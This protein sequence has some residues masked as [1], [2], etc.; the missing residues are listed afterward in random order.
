[1][2]SKKIVGMLLAAAFVMAGGISVMAQGQ[3]VQGVVKLRKADGTESPVAGATVEAYRTDTRSGKLPE[4]TTNEKGEFGWAAMPPSQVF[5]VAVSGSGIGPKIQPGVRGGTTTLVIIVEE[6]AG[7]RLSEE[8]VRQVVAASSMTEDERKIAEAERLKEIEKYNAEK[9]RIEQ[10]AKLVNEALQAGNAAFNSKQFDVAIARY[11]E[12]I[13]AQPNFAGSTPVLLYNRGVSYQRRA[14][15]NFNAAA[16]NPDVQARATAFTGARKDFGL[17]IASFHRAF[18]IL[19]D[20]NPSELSDP[21][22][23]TTERTKSLQAAAETI[24]NMAQSQQVD[25]EILDKARELSAAYVASENDRAKKEKALVEI[26]DVLR[27][28]GNSE[29]AITEYRKALEFAPKNID[30]MAGIGLSL[31]NSGFESDNRAQLQEG[32]NYLQQYVSA[33]PDTHKFK[34]DARALLE[35]LRDTHK[36]TPGRN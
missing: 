2:I 26:A 14:T 25:E 28:A 17:A 30:A 21:K 1:M 34:A 8:D 18:V 10:T 5:A 24:S 22:I 29:L 9:A 31:L 19:R 4:T 12:G 3:A 23:L 32:A 35:D 13:E 33:A 27:A 11:N 6:G 7:D 36:I 20:A 15:D 16:R